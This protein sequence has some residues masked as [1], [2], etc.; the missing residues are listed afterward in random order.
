MC[1]GYFAV[2]VNSKKQGFHDMFCNTYV[3][4][5]HMVSRVEPTVAT[6]EE[7]SPVAPHPVVSAILDDEMIEEEM[8]LEAEPA[9]KVPVGENQEKQ[10]ENQ[11][12]Q[13]APVYYTMPEKSDE[14]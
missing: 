13:I 6:P 10:S 3:V 7:A 9:Q 5:K 8:M 1:I 14:N 11:P 12:E 4:Y 2:I